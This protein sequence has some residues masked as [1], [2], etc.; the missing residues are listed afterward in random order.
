MDSNNQD[1]D[2]FKI[3]ETKSP[4]DFER[5][6]TQM[7]LQEE[8]IV[9]KP[10]QVSQV[11]NKF[12]TFHM[13]VLDLEPKS[14]TCVNQTGDLTKQLSPKKVNFVGAKPR[15]V[16]VLKLASLKVLSLLFKHAKK[17]KLFAY[18]YCLLPRCPNNPSKRGILELVEHPDWQIR[19]STLNLMSELFSASTVHLQLANAHCR[20]GSFT[21]VCLEFALALGR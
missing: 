10:A 6:H 21:P 12:L 8:K 3:E 13:S 19:E 11:I 4:V 18:W 20:S 2:C 14:S 7:S 5:L 16:Q 15:D 1:D 17:S 9:S